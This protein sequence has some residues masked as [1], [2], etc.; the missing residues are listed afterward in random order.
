MS[1]LV[2]DQVGTRKYE[3]GV[4]H[5]VLYQEDNGEFI[6]GVPWNGLVDVTTDNGDTNAADLFSGDVKIDIAIGNDTVSGTISAYTYP[7]EFEVCTGSVAAGPGFYVQQQGRNRFG[8]SYRTLIGNDVKGQEYGYKIH[9]LYNLAVISESHAHSTVSD[10]MDDIEL[11][12]DFDALPMI[13]DDEDYD[14]YSELVFDSTKFSPEFMESLETI[15]YGTETEAP[16]MPDLDELLDLYTEDEPMPIEWTGFP[17]ELLYPSTTL[18]PMAVVTKGLTGRTI[19]FYSSFF[20]GE[21]FPLTLTPNEWYLGAA[22]SVREDLPPLIPPDYIDYVITSATNLHYPPYYYR[23]VHPGGDGR[24]VRLDIMVFEPLTITEPIETTYWQSYTFQVP[25]NGKRIVANSSAWIPIFSLSGDPLLPPN[26]I[27]NGVEYEI[28]ATPYEG[29]PSYIEG[30]DISYVFTSGRTG[31]Y[32]ILTNNTDET[33][34]I[35]DV[36]YQ[37]GIGKFWI[38]PIFTYVVPPEGGE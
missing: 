29:A 1:K 37:A 27:I 2:W 33:V 34:S 35:P 14:P 7:D 31:F 10:S 32:L 30:M 38:T 26:A 4:D 11:N 21:S 8:L 24:T 9:L 17:N 15:L 3:V 13:T 6:N 22:T 12:W 28:H 25:L 20:Y 18:Y 5:G 16:R 23:V 36:N 19:D